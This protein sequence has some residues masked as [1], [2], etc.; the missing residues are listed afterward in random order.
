MGSSSIL[1][2]SRIRLAGVCL[3]LAIF[4]PVVLIAH[5]PALDVEV[6]TIEFLNVEFPV[7]MAFL[8]HNDFL[9]LELGGVV[10][11]IRLPDATEE[12]IL[13]LDVYLGGET[14]LLGIALH[15]D[16]IGTG[17]VYLFYTSDVTGNDEIVRYYWNGNRFLA[18]NSIYTIS[19]EGSGLH[20]GGIITF[21]PD[22]KLYVVIGDHRQTL[23]TT[24]RAGYP[25]KEFA[26]ILRLNDDGST[27]SDNPF[28][29]VPGW[30]RIFA[31]GIRNSF[32][33][34]F[35]SLTGHLWET[36]DGV[37]SYDEVN[38]VFPGMNGGWS[39]LMGPD[40]RCSLNPADLVMIPGSYYS[41]PEFSWSFTVVPTAITFLNSPRWPA[42]VRNDCVIAMGGA[43]VLDGI[44]R[45]KMNQDRSAF[46]L[47]EGFADGVADVVDDYLFGAL[48][49]ANLPAVTDLKV[50]PDGYLYALTLAPSGR[51]HRIRPR[52]PMGDINLDQNV[53]ED[54]MPLFFDLVLGNS[55]DPAQITQADFDG[56]GSVTGLDIQG[57]VDSL[58][59]P[60]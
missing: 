10:R 58:R 14:G 57:F 7:T 24:N 28:I 1:S 60:N 53:T 3:F 51:I 39:R 50:G 18:R 55:S 49:F 35:D 29:A 11:H 38:R 21:G 4:R 20:R 47:K 46:D 44:I 16:F 40:Y 30:E 25:H 45:L 56:D 19:G 48:S 15:P 36:E 2:S 54:D 32:G 9:V 41:N 6:T 34:A 31:Y 12:E 43:N 17:Y 23:M 22:R 13:F 59:L 33:I 37:S 42:S 26:C 8:G 52:F 5:P 27:P